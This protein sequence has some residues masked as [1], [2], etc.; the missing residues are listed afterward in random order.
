MRDHFY[1]LASH[2][3]AQ[4]R[5]PEV[6]LL[7]YSGETTDF[8]RFNQSRVRQPMHVRQASLAVRL[9]AGQRHDCTVISLCGQPAEDRTALAQAITAMRATLGSLPEDPYLLY[10]TEAATSNT[11]RT[12]R[13][14]TAA[15]AIEAVTREAADLDL[16]G[17]YASGPA[18]RG[19][20]SS[21]GARHW[22]EVDSFLFDFSVYHATDKAV[23]TMW[24]GERWDAAELGRRIASARAQLPYLGLPARSIAPGSYRSYLAP[25]AMEDLVSMFSWGGFSAKAQRTKQSVIQRLVDGEEAL[26]DLVDLVEATASGL[27]PLFDAAGFTRPAAVALVRAGRHAGSLASPRTAREY[28]L[29]ANGADEGEGAASL[30]MSA[31]TLPTEDALAALGTGLYVS[32]LHY[33]NFSDR[34]SCRVTGMTRFA[35]FWVEDGRIVAPLNV[36]RFD[37][38]LYS[39]LGPQLEAL[40]RESDWILSSSTYGG[41]SLAST[42]VPGALLAGMTYTL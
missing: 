38:S 34:P 35:T 39:L 1:D 22:H 26:S 29:A 24:G 15:E 19:F 9:I 40:T 7:N 4:L 36:M 3:E 31:G 28:G 25:A 16:V 27:E 41:R 33:L 8:I 20:A 37:D 23:K 32:N 18:Q 5:A 13:L 21:V 14:P 6:L 11:V 10:S 12:G 17:I 2:G 30:E 42:R